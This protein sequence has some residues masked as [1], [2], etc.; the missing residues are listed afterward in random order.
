MEEKGSEHTPEECAQKAI[1]GKGMPSGEQAVDSGKSRE[2]K[3]TS[4]EIAE[5]HWGKESYGTFV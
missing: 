3:W 5:P 2:P 4:T 1:K